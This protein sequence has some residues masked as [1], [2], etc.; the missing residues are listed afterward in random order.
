MHSFILESAYIYSKIFN[1]ETALV[2]KGFEAP[3]V[4]YVTR[5]WAKNDC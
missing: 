2:N 4:I 5:F 3:R 1:F